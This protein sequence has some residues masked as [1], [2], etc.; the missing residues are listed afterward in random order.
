MLVVSTELVW[1]CVIAILLRI[2]TRSLKGSALSSIS[3]VVIE[4]AEC[5]GSAANLTSPL[6]SPLT[7][8]LSRRHLLFSLY[9]LITLFDVI[10]SFSRRRPAAISL[11]TSCHLSISC[12]IP[13]PPSF[14]SFC[15]FEMSLYKPTDSNLASDHTLHSSGGAP[16][17]NPPTPGEAA[18]ADRTANPEHPSDKQQS[19]D[20]KPPSIA[21][22]ELDSAGKQKQ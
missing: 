4:E 5:V 10:R 20:P 14:L 19:A 12:R 18:A 22:E 7:D 15:L 9:N 6:T 2:R 11:L 1:C 13:S 17:I 8:H 21:D 16:K 3:G